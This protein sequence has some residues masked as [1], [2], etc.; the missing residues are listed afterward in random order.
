MEIVAALV[1]RYSDNLGGE[2]SL[3]VTQNGTETVRTVLPAQPSVAD[4]YRIGN[5]TIPISVVVP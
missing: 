5:D 3:K 1:A 2:V 4:L